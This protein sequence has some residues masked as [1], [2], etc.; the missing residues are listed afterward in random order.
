MSGSGSSVTISLNGLFV[1]T[2]VLLF[3]IVGYLMLAGWKRVIIAKWNSLFER[4]YY[5][6]DFENNNASQEE[7]QVQEE[8]HRKQVVYKRK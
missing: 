3:L 7:Q 1:L 2:L 6:A 5:K 4:K 8:H